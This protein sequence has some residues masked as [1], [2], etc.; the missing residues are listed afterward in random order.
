MADESA[1]RLESSFAA[2]NL[3]SEKP[4][5]LSTTLW[6]ALCAKRWLQG[7]ALPRENISALGD[8][9]AILFRTRHSIFGASTCTRS[10]ARDAWHIDALR[11][12]CAPPKKRAAG[13]FRPRLRYESYLTLTMGYP[14][15]ADITAADAAWGEASVSARAVV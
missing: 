9:L 7:A 12:S 10:L 6:N 8:L 15:S 13:I 3:R 2:A 1:A 4:I 11:A 14:L 5:H